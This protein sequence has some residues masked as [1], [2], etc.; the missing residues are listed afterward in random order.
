MISVLAEKKGGQGLMLLGSWGHGDM[1]RVKEKRERK[2]EQDSG[3]E[4]GY[5][6]ERQHA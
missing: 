2:G 3:G 5:K 1:E 4:G 6:V